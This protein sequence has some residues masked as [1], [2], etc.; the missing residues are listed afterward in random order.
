[1]PFYI[2]ARIAER[3]HALRSGGGAHY[4]FD[5]LKRGLFR[6]ALT[7]FGGNKRRAMKIDINVNRDKRGAS[8][9]PE[10]D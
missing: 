10:R 3:S 9:V 2:A 1:V 7:L 8:V 4:S 5:V 6:N